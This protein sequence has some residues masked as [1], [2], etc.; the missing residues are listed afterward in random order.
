M[1]MKYNCCVLILIDNINKK[2]L[3]CIS[4]EKYSIL[5]LC[6]SHIKKIMGQSNSVLVLL[7]GYCIN[8]S[9]KIKAVCGSIDNEKKFMLSIYYIVSIVRF[10]YQPKSAL[11]IP[12]TFTHV[13]FS[14]DLLKSIPYT[15]MWCW[16]QYFKSALVGFEPWEIKLGCKKEPISITIG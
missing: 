12:L 1:Y 6:I 4:D 16:D 10:L 7:K 11:R 13:S 9:S 5:T 2:I 3:W 15:I 8:S 14:N